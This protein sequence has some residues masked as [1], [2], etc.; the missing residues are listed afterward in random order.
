MPVKDPSECLQWEFRSVSYWEQLV[1]EQE[2]WEAIRLFWRFNLEIFRINHD[3]HF[4]IGAFHPGVNNLSQVPYFEF[5]HSHLHPGK[6]GLYPFSLL[7]K[8]IKQWNE[9]VTTSRFAGKGNFA[10]PGC[11]EQLGSAVNEGSSL[12]PPEPCRCLKTFSR[13]Q[14]NTEKW[15][16][17]IFF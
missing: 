13:A 15:S 5:I 3:L 12:H 2:E 16:C 14:W 8:E 9:L 17:S 11:W 1:W 6:E 10:F 4:F 7:R